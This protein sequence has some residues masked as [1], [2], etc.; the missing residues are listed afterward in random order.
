LSGNDSSTSHSPRRGRCQCSAPSRK[1]VNQR[2]CLRGRCV[3][4]RE[5]EGSTRRMSREAA[6]VRRGQGRWRG[7]RGGRLVS[8][9]ASYWWRRGPSARLF[10]VK[11]APAHGV[12]TSGHFYSLKSRLSV[13]LHP[14]PI[15]SRR[16]HPL[17]CTRPLTY[18]PSYKCP[19]VNTPWAGASFTSK[20]RALGPRHHQ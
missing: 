13:K 1:C 12:L 8:G 11:L 15:A 3:G 14:L 7:S 6:A 5:L 16:L 19:L 10:D 20:R 9:W 4:A 18:R 17:K 2:P